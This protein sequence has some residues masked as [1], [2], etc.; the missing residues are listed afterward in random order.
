MK[1]RIDQLLLISLVVLVICY[2]LFVN[3]KNTSIQPTGN[4]IR[5]TTPEVLHAEWDDAAFPL[6]FD[7]AYREGTTITQGTKT[8]TF[9]T[10]NLGFLM[11]ES[12]KVICCDNV[13]SFHAKPFTQVFPIGKFPVELA[14]LNAPGY[15]SVALARVTFKNDTVSRW[16]Y[17]LL[18]GQQE[19]SIAREDIYCYSVDAA[20]ALFIDSVANDQLSNMS[21]DEW[22]NTFVQQAMEHQYG[23]L[24]AFNNH[25]MAIFTTGEGDGCYC[26]YIGYNRKGEVCY[27]LTDFALFRWWN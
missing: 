19:K 25:N 27:L 23:F 11:V 5:D 9:T 6:F 1:N 17:A 4:T 24:H 7:A 20:T 13:N 3:N 14:L 16:T 21:E 15:S 18:P 2:F 8:Y 12:G 22:V 10:T 26:T